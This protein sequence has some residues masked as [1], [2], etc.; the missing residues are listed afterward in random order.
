MVKM[1]KFQVFCPIWQI[2]KCIHQHETSSV[3]PDY[4]CQEERL[5]WI[6]THSG[7]P[8]KKP[9]KSKFG[10]MEQNDHYIQVWHSDG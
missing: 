3:T 10:R 2:S 5:Y 7:K 6:R 8:T 9:F 4:E 1:T